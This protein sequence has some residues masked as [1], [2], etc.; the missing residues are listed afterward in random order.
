MKLEQHY[1]GVKCE[2]LTGWERE[3]VAHAHRSPGVCPAVSREQT[4]RCEALT[5]LQLNPFSKSATSKRTKCKNRIQTKHTC[6]NKAPCCVKS[7]LLKNGRTL[8]KNLLGKLVLP[9]PLCEAFEE[10]TD[11]PNRTI[12]D[13]N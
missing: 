11:S 13:R 7:T 12:E 5:M 6:V 8:R 10:F 4:S 2:S 9:S 3:I 1:S